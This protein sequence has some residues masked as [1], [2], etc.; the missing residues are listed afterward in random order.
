MTTNEWNGEVMHTQR[1]PS[2]KEKAMFL[3]RQQ[4]GETKGLETN[5]PALTPAPVAKADMGLSPEDMPVPAGTELTDVELTIRGTLHVYGRVTGT[6]N[7]QQLIVHAG[8]HIAGSVTVQGLSTV[9]GTHEGSLTSAN[10]CVTATGVASGLLAARGILKLEGRVDAE[11][12]GETV[13][14]ASSASIAGQVTGGTLAM[15]KG[16]RV[17]AT[18]TV[19][20]EDTG[21]G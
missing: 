21:E 17:T 3:V 9:S 13:F 20:H 12:S 19:G 2:L 8:G 6:I 4:R 14:V 16:A 11:M 5:A 7:A 10:I 1:E 18:I 15:Q